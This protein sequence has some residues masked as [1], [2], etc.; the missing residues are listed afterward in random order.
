[1]ETDSQMPKVSPTTNSSGQAY[2]F[3][4]FLMLFDMRR[5]KKSPRVLLLFHKQS[6]H[7]VTRVDEHI[8]ESTQAAQYG[9]LISDVFAIRGYD[10]PLWLKSRIYRVA[11]MIVTKTGFMPRGSESPEE[12][13]TWTSFFSK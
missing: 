2:K 10:E 5:T 6:R 7:F 11:E 4:S 8:P 1:M 9:K 12:L 13:I 3:P